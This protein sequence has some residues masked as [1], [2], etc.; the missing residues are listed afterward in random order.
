M[1]ELADAGCRA[2]GVVGDLGTRDGIGAAAEAVTEP[3]GEP[4]INGLPSDFAGATVFLAG[5]GSGYVTGRSLFVDGG[6][7][8]H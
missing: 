2:V 5:A 3:F 1:R 6:L 7:S 4:D 8:V